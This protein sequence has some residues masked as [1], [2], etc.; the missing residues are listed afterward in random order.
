[1]RKIK[2]KTRIR[3]VVCVRVENSYRNTIK[4]QHYWQSCQFNQ[5]K[6]LLPLYGYG[7]TS[8]L[9]KD[10]EKVSIKFGGKI[11]KI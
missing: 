11:M 8:I 9:M 7:Q 1:M 2:L 10:Y 3:F 4:I 5:T 6:F